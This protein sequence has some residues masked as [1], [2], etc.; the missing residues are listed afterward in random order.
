MNIK[1]YQIRKTE[2]ADMEQLFTVADGNKVDINFIV[3]G[4]PYRA[5][6]LPWSDDD[7]DSLGQNFTDAFYRHV[8]EVAEEDIT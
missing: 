8:L 1:L 5:H 7:L 6:G 3:N 2:P 4:T